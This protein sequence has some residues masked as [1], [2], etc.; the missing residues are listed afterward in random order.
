MW[1][2]DAAPVPVARLR[3][4][5]AVAPAVQLH[6]WTACGMVATATAAPAQ[7]LSVSSRFFFLAVG[8]ETSLSTAGRVLTDL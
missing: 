1:T 4:L 6:R 7:R 8:K 3:C 2:G 5:A